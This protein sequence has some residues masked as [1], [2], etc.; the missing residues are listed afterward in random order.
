MPANVH[1]RS[2]SH[3]AAVACLPCPFRVCELAL[4]GAGEVCGSGLGVW[5]V[6]GLFDALDFA[7]EL[8]GVVE[9]SLWHCYVVWA[10]RQW[11][12][13][14]WRW[15]GARQ[16]PRRVEGEGGESGGRAEED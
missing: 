14:E 8:R 1:A 11:G 7:N 15:R 3:L 2:L 13:W 5:G 10:W 16:A 12:R 6:L 9:S 4:D